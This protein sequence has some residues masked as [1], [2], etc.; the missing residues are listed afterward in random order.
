[1]PMYEYK[2]LD[3]GKEAVLNLSVKDH[4]SGT[5]VCPACHSKRVERVMSPV[6]AKTSRKS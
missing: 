1:M 3:C 5:A 6:M 2:C 4:D